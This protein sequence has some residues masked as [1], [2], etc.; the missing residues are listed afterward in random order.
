MNFYPL[1]SIIISAYNAEKYIKETIESVLNQSWPN[2]EIIVVNDG[3]SDNTSLIAEGYVK[4]GIKLI[5]QNNKGQDAAL[6][7]GY[8]HSNGAYIK[9]M[10]SDDLINPEMVAIQMRVLNGSEEHVAYG[11]WA[12]F[13]NDQPELADFTKLD[14]W[15]DMAPLD[16]LTS[17]PEGVMLQCG[18]MLVPRIL[19]DRAGLWDERLV[20]FNDTEFFG[21]VLLHSKG[22]KFTEGAKL[23]YRSAQS[24]SLSAL[25]NHK[26]YECTLFATNLI[27][28]Q[29]LAVE[30]SYRIR[31]LISNTYLNQYYQIY[32]RFRDLTVLLEEKIALYGVGTEKPGG[33]TIFKII[34][35][36]VGWKRAKRIQLF[37]YKMGYQPRR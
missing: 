30:D 7:N 29:L 24:G 14:Y 37:F 17:R 12:R 21:R 9:F 1:V 19:I 23:F 33:G 15:K 8:K 32:P 26:F 11:E 34:K 22:V 10:D 2:L 28:D 36:L 25:R 3:S 31:K 13:Y 5:T 4:N 35:V 27:A 18:I 6:N 16:F 20:H